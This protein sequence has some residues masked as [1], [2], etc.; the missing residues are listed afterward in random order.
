LTLVWSNNF[1]SGHVGE[2]QIDHSK[3]R[4][5]FYRMFVRSIEDRTAIAPPNPDPLR[6]QNGSLRTPNGIKQRFERLLRPRAIPN[7]DQGEE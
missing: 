3:S 5:H 7:P 4:N 1:Q 6:A 2:S